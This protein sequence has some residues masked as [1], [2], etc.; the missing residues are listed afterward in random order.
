MRQKQN[1]NSNGKPSV[2]SC[3][4]IEANAKSRPTLTIGRR[5]GYDKLSS[6]FRTQEK[7]KKIDLHRNM[8]K[9]D[10]QEPLE[11]LRSIQ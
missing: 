8:C 7:L 6:V 9:N 10:K 4:Q 11:I 3:I 1:L 5:E 2:L